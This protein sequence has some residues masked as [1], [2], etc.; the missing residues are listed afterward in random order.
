MPISIINPAS[1]L[2]LRPAAGNLLEDEQGQVFPIVNGIPRICEPSNYTENFG[3]QWNAFSA[4]QMDRPEE[5]LKLSEDRFFQATGWSPEAMAGQDVLEVGSGA[6]RFS[7]VVLEQTQA[8]LW[9]VDYSSAVEANLANNAKIGGD[10]LR[11]FQASIY[12][13]PFSDGAFDKVFCMGVLQH[14]P[15]FEASVRAL[16]AKAKPGGEIVVDFYPIK[17]FWT[18]LHAKY[19]LRPITK[20]M[21]HDRLLGLIERHAD[22]LIRLSQRL[23]GV[24]LHALTRF[25]PICD[26]RGTL[27][28]GLT[29]EQLRE[30]VVLDTFD[31]YSPEYD[32]PQRVRAVAQMFERN[33]ARVTYAD[34]MTMGDTTSA[35]VRGVKRG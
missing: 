29:P 32:N 11:L 26:I 34:L 10:R 23:D 19:L 1:G 6:G 12:E 21:P 8:R 35:V 18:K 4:T 20:R 7:R 13:L 27:P 9:S 14:T 28:R 30:W 5:G 22:R 2:E 33:G 24:G 15:D 17:G 31:Q 25:V 3:K 16:I